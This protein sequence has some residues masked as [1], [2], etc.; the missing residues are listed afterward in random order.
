VLR[1][2]RVVT[3]RSA[4]GVFAR[5]ATLLAGQAVIDRNVSGA[6]ARIRGWRAA[7]PGRRFPEVVTERGGGD[8]LYRTLARRL[9]R[10]KR[11]RSA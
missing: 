9:R 3:P 5:E 4:P 11:L 7:T 2:W 6:A 8:P 1:K 10:R